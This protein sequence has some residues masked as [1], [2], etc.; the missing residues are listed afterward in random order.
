MG[1]LRVLPGQVLSVSNARFAKASL[2]PCSSTIKKNAHKWLHPCSISHFSL[3]LLSLVLFLLSISERSLE[4]S[5]SVMQR[6]LTAA[7]FS[8]SSPGWRVPRLSASLHR[9]GSDH[10]SAFPS[11]SFSSSAPPLHWGPQAMGQSHSIYA[12]AQL[13]ESPCLRDGW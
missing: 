1:L 3:R 2:S 5:P 6:L 4:P 8:S 10:L 11:S 13:E 12:G 9:W 7:H